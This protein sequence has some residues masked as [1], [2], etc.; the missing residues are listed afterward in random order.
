MLIQ[1]MAQIRMHKN[2]CVQNALYDGVGCACLQKKIHAI[3]NGA[4]NV[5]ENGFKNNK[6]NANH[7]SCC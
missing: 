4:G 1:F 5:E 2:V 7:I 3:K 6:N